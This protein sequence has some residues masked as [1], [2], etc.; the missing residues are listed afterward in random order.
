M[1]GKSKEEILE[2]ILYLFQIFKEAVEN[3]IKSKQFV[4]TL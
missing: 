3:L 2:Y 4:K 1:I